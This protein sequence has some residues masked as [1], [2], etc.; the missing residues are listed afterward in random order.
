MK[1]A[2]MIAAILILSL[3]FAIGGANAQPLGPAESAMGRDSQMADYQRIM[4]TDHQRGMGMIAG[5]RMMPENLMEARNHVMQMMLKL[6]LDQKQK[7]AVHEMID[8]TAKELIK[9]RSDLLISKIDLE[10]ILQRDP[11]DISAAET[12]MRQME[13]MKTDMFL[14][15]LKALEEI[16]SMLTPEQRDKLKGMMEMHMMPG[17][18]MMEEKKHLYDEKRMTK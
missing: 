6:G 4:P 1:Q 3:V 16:K 13:A 9:K 8:K 14:T 12:K 2:A 17:K 7:E 18:G 11:I 5:M 15:H 10:D